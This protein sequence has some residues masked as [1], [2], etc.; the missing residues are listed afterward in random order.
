M[1]PLNLTI[2]PA[3]S[4]YSQAVV[5][6]NIAQGR[7]AFDYI[8]LDMH[9]TNSIVMTRKRLT[10]A[11]LA[12][13]WWRSLATIHALVEIGEEAQAERETEIAKTLERFAILPSYDEVTE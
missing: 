4:K 8:M 6:N 3:L 13:E 5:D 1:K 2:Y 10:P 9:C 11:E 12:A 7:R